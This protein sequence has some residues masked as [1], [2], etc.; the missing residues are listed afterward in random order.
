MDRGTSHGRQVPLKRRLPHTLLCTHTDEGGEHH[1]ARPQLRA[2]RRDEDLQ[3]LLPVTGATADGGTV[4]REAAMAVE[5]HAPKDP[6]GLSATAK[7][8]QALLGK[9][10]HLP[11][12]SFFASHQ[13]Q[14]L[15]P[16]E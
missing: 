10:H 15:A 2:L 3:G 6:Q 4:G 1:G 8:C 16:L 14:S 9:P 7:R 11:L 12:Q 5:F 13:G